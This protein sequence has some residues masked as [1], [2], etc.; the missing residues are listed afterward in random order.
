MKKSLLLVLG[1]PIAA[2]VLSGCAGHN[3]ERTH[4]WSDGSKWTTKSMGDTALFTRG[5]THWQ[6]TKC[7]EAGVCVQEEPTT[8][9]NESLAGTLA[10]PA[11]AAILRDSFKDNNNNIN[12]SSS[13]SATSS[14]TSSSSSN[15]NMG[16]M[17]GGGMD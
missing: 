9:S 6:V 1:V 5:A 3:W 11:S 14:S 16:W 4:G 2:L 7:S 12:N 15:T 10:G 17:G 8:F 13:S